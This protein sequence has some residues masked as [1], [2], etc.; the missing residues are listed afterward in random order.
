MKKIWRFWAKALGEKCGDT[1]T[2]AD[3]VALVRTII[4]LSYLITNIFIVGGVVR[5]WNDA[6]NNH[7]VKVNHEHQISSFLL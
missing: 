2:E 1:D 4:F 5:H 6:Q 7:C 3:K